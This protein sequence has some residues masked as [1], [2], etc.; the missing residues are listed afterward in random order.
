VFGDQARQYVGKQN[1][2]GPGEVVQPDV[3]EFDACRVYAEQGR[4][5]TLIADCHVAQADRAVAVLQQRAGDDSDRIGEVDDP[6][7]WCAVLGYPLGDVE[8]HRY[9]AQRLGEATGTGGFLTDAVALQRKGFVH[10]TR[11]LTADPKLDEDHAGAL[12]P[13]INVVGPRQLGAVPVLPKDPL[14]ER[15]NERQPLGG[16][17]DQGQLGYRQHVSQSCDAVDQF[18]CVRR[19]ATDHGELHPLTPVNVTPSTRAFC[20]KKNTTITGSMTM[21]VAAIVVFH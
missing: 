5:L 7:A 16:R 1:A 9:R 18:W 20:A 13:G 17:I 19:A 21:R 10:S 4:R 8:Y 3:I 2:P 14:R 11:S 15:S 6:R 12:D